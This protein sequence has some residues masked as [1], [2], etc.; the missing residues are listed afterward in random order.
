MCVRGGGWEGGKGAGAASIEA[1]ASSAALV[2][3]THPLMHVARPRLHPVC[4]PIPHSDLDAPVLLIRRTKL[5]G[6]DLPLVGD[7]PQ[8]ALVPHRED[9]R[10]A[11][12]AI[13]MVLVDFGEDVGRVLRQC[14]RR[15]RSSRRLGIG[16][17]RR[18]IGLLPAKDRPS[19]SNEVHAWQTSI[20]NTA[21]VYCGRTGGEAAWARVSTYKDMS[22]S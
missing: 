18:H 1:A 16:S 15:I 8:S 13:R 11:E 2:G 3:A 22:G 6:F 7:P 19:K 20:A 5:A 4:L 10:I 21:C 17:R 9:L 14:E 12:R